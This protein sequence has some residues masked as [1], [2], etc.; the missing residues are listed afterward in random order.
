MHRAACVILR[1]RGVRTY[2]TSRVKLLG[3]HDAYKGITKVSIEKRMYKMQ[4]KMRN[5]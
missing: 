3:S 5:A 1:Q 2:A 4:G